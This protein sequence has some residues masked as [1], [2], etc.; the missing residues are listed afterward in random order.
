MANARQVFGEPL[1]LLIEAVWC[2]W[3]W[4]EW[5]RRNSSTRMYYLMLLIL[6]TQV[7]TTSIRGYMCWAVLAGRVVLRASASGPKSGVVRGFTTAAA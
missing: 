2:K 3:M 7:V 4:M 1:S 5:D 6:A